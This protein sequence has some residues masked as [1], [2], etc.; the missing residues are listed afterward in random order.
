MWG[1]FPTFRYIF[2]HHIYVFFMTCGLIIRIVNL[3]NYYQ[4]SIDIEFT[5]KL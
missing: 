1:L 5:F 2:F 3:G 4:G